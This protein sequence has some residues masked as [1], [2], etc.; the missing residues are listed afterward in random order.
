MIKEQ[1][2]IYQITNNELDTISDLKL[3]TLLIGN[4]EA[5]HKLAYKIYEDCQHNL[6][7]VAAL[8]LA[9]LTKYKGIGETVA[10]RIV[11]AFQL[12]RR[13]NMAEALARPQI[14]SSKD[15]FNIIAPILAGLAKEEFWVLVLNRANR[16]IKK[17]QH[18]AGG[19]SGTI[20]DVKLL[21]RQ[22]L[23][24]RKINGIILC[25]NHPSGNTAPSQADLD[26]TK[27]IQEACKYLDLKVLDHLIV[28]DNSYLSFADEGYL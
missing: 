26:V 1:K 25:H 16:V 6:S 19:T 11:A 18:S 23:E 15:A 5:D 28:T 22:A 2:A 7:E 9:E 12:G 17:V 21:L 27:K 3:L 24:V 14:R 4:S 20:V 8:T 13:R 10:A